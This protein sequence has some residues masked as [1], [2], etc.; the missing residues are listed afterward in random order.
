[1]RPKRFDRIF[2]SDVG[3]IRNSSGIVVIDRK[4]Q[5]QFDSR[6]A[7]LTALYDNGQITTLRA[8][9]DGHVSIEQLVEQAREKGL[10]RSDLLSDL[11]RKEFLWHRKSICPRWHDSAGNE[12]ERENKKAEHTLECLGA[13]D[14]ALPYMGKSKETRRRYETSFNKLKKSGFLDDDARVSDLALINF[15]ELR[16]DWWE[17]SAA[18]WNHLGRALSRFLTIH[19]G[20]GRKGETHPARVEIMDRFSMEYEGEGRLVDV[21]VDEFWNIVLRTPEHAQPGY[22]V[23]AIGMLRIGEYE[24]LDDKKYLNLESCT[25]RIPGGK[26]GGRVVK[27][28]EEYREWFDR[29]IPCV[30]RHG[31][32]RQYF[33]RARKEAGREDVWLRDLRHLGGQWASDEGATEEQIGTQYGHR[34]ASMT[35]KYTRQKNKGQVA[36]AVA[37]K[38]SKAKVIGSIDDTGRKQA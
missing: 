9:R 3:R 10:G 25:V 4:T 31:W 28:P 7:V 17:G 38:L 23:L 15:N 36:A 32:L 14:K 11:K 35:R 26:T 1:M 27:F 19:F 37:R 21:S 6:D 18:D 30:L 8:F 2:G 33:V 5:K 12:L 34:T 29:G 20:G 24:R 16:G 13:F 22:V